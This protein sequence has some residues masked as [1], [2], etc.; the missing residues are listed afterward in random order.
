M[1]FMNSLREAISG[2]SERGELTIEDTFVR[3]RHGR[4]RQSEVASTGDGPVR[5]RHAAA[6][7]LPS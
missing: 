5:G 7:R 3:A 4:P 1:G 6:E 2:R